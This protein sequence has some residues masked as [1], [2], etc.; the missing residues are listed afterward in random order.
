MITVSNADSLKHSVDKA[1]L[2]FLLTVVRKTATLTV[3]M[4]TQSREDKVEIF[5]RLGDLVKVGV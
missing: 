5:M 1:R 4:A 3:L 2:S